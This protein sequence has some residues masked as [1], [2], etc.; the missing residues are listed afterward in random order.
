LRYFIELS[1]NGK[2]YHGWQIQPNE[3]S[4]QETIEKAM[5]LLLN[6]NISVIGCGRTDT[7]VHASQFYLHFD[8]DHPIDKEKLKFKLN[9]FLPEDIAIFQII[10]VVD[11]AHARFQALSRSYQYNIYLGKNVFQRDLSLKVSQKKLDVDLMNEAAKMLMNYSDFKCFSKNKTGVKTY[12]CS[13]TE[14]YWEVN[15]NQLIFNISANRFLRNMVRAIVG[16]LLEV[17]KGKMSID[18]F[19]VVVESRDR[20]LAGTSVEAKGLFLTAVLYPKNIFNE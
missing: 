4:I 5:S 15:E 9:S 10:S 12:L 16:T 8:Y 14:A 2:N 20:A 13:V 1:Y 18:G 3:I 6:I 7:G 17:G 11:D 19:K